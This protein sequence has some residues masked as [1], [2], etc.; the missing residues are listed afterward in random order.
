MLTIGDPAPDF[1]L[2]SNEG[3]IDS[4]S[5]RG[6]RYVLFFYPKDDTPGCTTE[7]CQ[8]RDLRAAFDAAGVHVFGVS[9]LDAKSKKKFAQKHALNFPLLADADH[10]LAEAFGVWVEK[11]MYGKKYMGIQRSTFAV[12]ADGRISHAWEKVTPDG[13]A[14]EVL[15]ALTTNH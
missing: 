1:S 6:T 7:A 9:I 8:F 2:D 12:D 11:S 4:Q 13:H 14:D 10:T 3:R 5:L 15:R